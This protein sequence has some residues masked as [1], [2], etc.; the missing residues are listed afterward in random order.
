MTAFLATVEDIKRIK[1]RSAYQLILEVDQSAIDTVL[2]VLGGM[3]KSGTSVHVAV[4]RLN[5][6]FVKNHK[7]I[8]IST[9]FNPKL[10]GPE[11]TPGERAVTRAAMLCDDIEFQRWYGVKSANE[12][13]EKLRFVLGVRSRREIATNED[14][15][16]KFLA[17]ETEFLQ[18]TGRIA[19]IRG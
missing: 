15:F 9:D 2:D 17:I 11:K 8:T 3:P 19:E 4:A 13:A 18:R 12:A 5:P 10:A 6:D 16:K 14:S 7:N 1:T